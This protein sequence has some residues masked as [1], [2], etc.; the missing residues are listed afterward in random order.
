[1][2]LF[3]GADYPRAD[4][5]FSDC[6]PH[7]VLPEA[8]STDPAQQSTDSAQQ[9]ETDSS[10]LQR[11]AFGT[12]QQLTEMGS[13]LQLESAGLEQ[14]PERA[15]DQEQH[16][17]AGG[18]QQVEDISKEGLTE[19]D[20]IQQSPER[21]FIQSVLAD[22]LALALLDDSKMSSSDNR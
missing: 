15:Y 17:N 18:Q 14:Y 1:M 2:L 10:Q 19:F 21:A 16:H 7:Q 6:M 4:A 3:S 11:H 5:A 9:S 8:Y 12:Q 20:R 13:E 22:D